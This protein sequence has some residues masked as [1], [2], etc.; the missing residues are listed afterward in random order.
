MIV[1]PNSRLS[2]IADANLPKDRLDVDFDG[3]VGDIKSTCD[4]FVGFALHKTAENSRL[5][6]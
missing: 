1:R 3:R 2:A 5:L 6:L 4:N